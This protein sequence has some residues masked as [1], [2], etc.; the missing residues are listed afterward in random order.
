VDKKSIGTLVGAGFLAASGVATAA[1]ISRG[2]R[3]VANPLLTGII[4]RYDTYPGNPYGVFFQDEEGNDVLVG[5]YLSIWFQHVWDYHK[6]VYDNL[7]KR[8]LTV[9][10]SLLG[11]GHSMKAGVHATDRRTPMRGFNNWG[12]KAS[13]GYIDDGG[14]YWLADTK[15]LGEEGYYPIEG[16]EWRFYPSMDQATKHWLKVMRENYPLAYKELFNRDPDP[17]QYQYGL[18]HGTGGKKYATGSKDM[19]EVVQWALDNIPNML[20]EHFGYNL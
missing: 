14:L 17:D 2:G 18:E 15:E 8:G 1:A 16:E 4:P 6:Y 10:G 3:Q 5:E 9:Y 13:K 11:V 20:N 12:M 19:A 7:R